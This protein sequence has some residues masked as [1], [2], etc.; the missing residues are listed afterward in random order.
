MKN[1]KSLDQQA[2]EKIEEQRIFN[3]PTYGQLTFKEVIYKISLFM[4][5]EPAAGYKVIIG[6]DSQVYPIGVSF[7]SAIIVHREGGGAIYFWHK[8][9]DTENYWVLKTRMYEEAVRSMELTTEFME[10]YK[11]EGITQFNTE[12]HVD[13]GA[14]GK[15]REL[16]SEVVGMIEGYGFAVKTKPQAFGAASVADRHT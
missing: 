1:L 6:T 10:E 5:S 9:V 3:S 7:V 4:R 2:L 12:I 16:I 8:T 11:T 13:I 15:T 14:Q